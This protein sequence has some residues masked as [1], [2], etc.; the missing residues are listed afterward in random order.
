MPIPPN[1]RTPGQTGHTADHNDIS[2]EL[3]AQ[4]ARLAALEAGGVP[5]A[6]VV[7]CSDET[8]PLTTGQKVEFRMPHAMTVSSVRASLT[9]A[10]TSGNPVID[11]REG[12]TSI[13]STKPS[14]DANEKTSTTAA[15]AAVLSDTSLADDASITI[16][17][18]TAG[19]AAA[20]LK[21]TFIGTR[22][23]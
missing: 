16:H 18:D 8:T 14:I 22:S 7:A 19:T 15:T 17:V 21:V 6:L 12:G 20:G 2:S 13:F 11:V 10:S 23:A 1:N 5:V 3:T 9:T 4:D